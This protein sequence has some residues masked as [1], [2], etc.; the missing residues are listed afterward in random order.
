MKTTTNKRRRSSTK[1]LIPM[2]TWSV[3]TPQCFLI[4]GTSED[5][6]WGVFIKTIDDAELIHAGKVMSVRQGTSGPTLPQ[7]RA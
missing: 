4:E 5:V 1:V 2:G 3:K 6:A 7:L